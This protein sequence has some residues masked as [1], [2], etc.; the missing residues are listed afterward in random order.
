[1]R[2]FYK[3]LIFTLLTS[4]TIACSDD[5]EPSTAP[6]IAFKSI[7]PANAIE[8]VDPI[9]ITITYYDEDGDLGE[10]DATV[11]NLYVT[12]SR[13][14]VKFEYR[15]QQLAPSG[16]NVPIGGELTISIDPLV[17]TNGSSSESVVFS[18][19]C[20]DRAGN[21]SNVDQ[22]TSITISK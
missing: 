9:S 5:E 7:T 18:I 1:M 3:L 15:I 21:L 4:L 13:N 2:I 8:L 22:A 14:N 10:N 11:K 6:Q 16:A 12:D 17:I 19:Q 20:E